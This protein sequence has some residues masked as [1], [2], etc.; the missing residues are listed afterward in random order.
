V[1]VFSFARGFHQ[2]YARS[3]IEASKQS[4]LEKIINL[5]L[6]GEMIGCIIRTLVLLAVLVH[7]YE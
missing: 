1:D 5:P 3:G 4:D 7:P 6:T 2:V